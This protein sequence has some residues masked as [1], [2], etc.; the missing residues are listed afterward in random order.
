A[1]PR[2]VDRDR[3][4]VDGEEGGGENRAERTGPGED[5]RQHGHTL[6]RHDHDRRGAHESTGSDL[7]VA[8]CLPEGIEPARFGQRGGGE[9]EREPAA[10]HRTDGRVNHGAASRLAP[11]PTSSISRT[12][13]PLVASWTVTVGGSVASATSTGCSSC[14]TRM[15]ST[16]VCGKTCVR[17]HSAVP[18]RGPCWRTKAA[19]GVSMGI[20][21]TRR[22]RG[23]ARGGGSPSPPG[24]RACA[25]GRGRGEGARRGAGTGRAPRG[26]AA[27]RCATSTAGRRR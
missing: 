23:G 5:E 24:P 17:T 7:V 15:P 2:E 4:G 27:R 6:E 1:S 25:C 8:E 16:P 9:H 22:P 3:G 20:R 13:V 10:E 21:W 18:P 19:S 12:T 11:R 14:V 26:A